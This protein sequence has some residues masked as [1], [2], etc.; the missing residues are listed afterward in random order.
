VERLCGH[1]AR[2]YWRFP[3][4]TSE[5]SNGL[6]KTNARENRP[7]PRQ[8][9]SCVRKSSTSVKASTARVRRS[10]RLQSAFRRRDAR[11]SI[12]SRPRKEQ[13][14]SGPAKVQPALTRADMEHR[15]A[16]SHQ[17]NALAQSNR[18]SSAKDIRRALVRHSLGRPDPRPQSARVLKGPLQ[19]ARQ[20]VPKVPLSARPRLARQRAREK[21][22]PMREFEVWSK[23]REG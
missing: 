19:L 9:N 14:L 2:I 22:T 13:P 18:R 12:S 3:C 4:Q 5:R 21:C 7:A 8:A 16:G 1:T 6:A 11:A 23:G 20:L 15:R 10:R 17:P